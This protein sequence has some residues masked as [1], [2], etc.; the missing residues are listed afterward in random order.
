MASGGAWA[1][2]GSFMRKCM[3]LVALLLG[4]AGGAWAQKI[5]APAG[6]SEASGS[7]AGNPD[8]TI[9]AMASPN[10]FH[11][12]LGAP[13]G[14]RALMG[15]AAPVASAAL[16]AAA[17]EPQIFSRGDENGRWQLGLGFT[18]VKFRSPAIDV[19]MEGLNTSVTYFTNDWLGVEGNITAAFGRKIF[20]DDRTKYAGITG[21]AKIVMRERRWEPWA[22]V[23]FGMAHVN[24]Q[25]AGVGKNGV[26]MQ[27][28]G[29]ADFLNRR[30]ISLRV[31]GDWVRTQLYSQSQNNFQV[32]TGVVLH[33]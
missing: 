30:Q 27:L 4:M 33:F 29:G 23:L 6:A 8:R 18:Y 28:G 17:P 21:G 11:D 26:A 10:T 3:R 22:H 9:G 12:V 15:F 25:L 2:G 24:P 5:A 14:S 1:P 19:G 32:V 31:E 20:V 13:V 7:S 16:A